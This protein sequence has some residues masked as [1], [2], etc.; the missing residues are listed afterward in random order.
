VVSISPLPNRL[1]Q[2]YPLIIYQ[3]LIPPSVAVHEAAAQKEIA[4]VNLKVEIFTLS[5]IIISSS[6]KSSFETSSVMKSSNAILPYFTAFR[7][8]II[9]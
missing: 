3:V 8:V 4:H 2:T 6:D 1:S 7:T 9:L 5:T